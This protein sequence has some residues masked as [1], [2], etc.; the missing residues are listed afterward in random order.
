M[1][2]FLLAFVSVS[3]VLVA[4]HGGSPHVPGPCSLFRPADVRQTTASAVVAVRNVPSIKSNRI[5]LCS[6]ET[7][8]PFGAVVVSV[9]D[10]PT[11]TTLAHFTH[12]D[13]NTQLVRG[14]GDGAYVYGGNSL[15]VHRGDIYFVLGTQYYQPDSPHILEALAR[16]ALRRL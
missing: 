11:P 15:F 2:R 6:Y 1:R 13:Q 10:S 4:C 7:T 9:T 12:P 16:L 3:A 8:G 5:R 14:L